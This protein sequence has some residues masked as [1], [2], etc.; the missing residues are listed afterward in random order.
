[1]TLRNVNMAEKAGSSAPIAERGPVAGSHTRIGRNDKRNASA[2]W[3][4]PRPAGAEFQW[5]AASAMGTNVSA[6]RLAPPTRAPSM[7]GWDS[8]SA[9]LAGFTEPP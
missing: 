8:N 4:F 3:G 9:A 5:T 2:R 7:S 6:F 1:M